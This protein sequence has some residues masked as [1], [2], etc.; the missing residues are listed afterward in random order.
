MCNDFQTSLLLTK[1]I[2]TSREFDWSAF[3]GFEKTDEGTSRSKLS[4]GLITAIGYSGEAHFSYPEC[5]RNIHSNAVSMAF[6]P[7]YLRNLVKRMGFDKNVFWGTRCI[8][9]GKV[10]RGNAFF[11]FLI[12]WGNCDS[13][14]IL[15]VFFVAPSSEH[16]G[17]LCSV[18]SFSLA[19][20]ILETVN[21]R[22][23]QKWG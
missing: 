13:W 1:K 4:S 22:D 5:Y 10:L 2:T 12:V 20:E 19:V 17:R 7:C 3:V 15:L 11:S 16:P 8:W 6:C 18:L 14:R 21:R 9:S 23:R